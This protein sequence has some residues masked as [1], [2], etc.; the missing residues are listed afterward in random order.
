M[1]VA[2]VL[3]VTGAIATKASNHKIGDSYNW[4]AT[5][6][7]GN[8]IHNGQYVSGVDVGTAQSDFGCDGNTTPC[9]V[10]VTGDNGS[11]LPSPIYI[12]V[13]GS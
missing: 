11:V 5:D 10:T 4:Q 9:A 2:I 6:D 7:M 8:V 12:Y 13:T 3:G 1:M